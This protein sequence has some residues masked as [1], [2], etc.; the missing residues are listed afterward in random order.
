MGQHVSAKLLLIQ[1]FLLIRSQKYH[2]LIIE[3]LG[4]LSYKIS[5]KNTPNLRFQTNKVN[6]PLMLPCSRSK[7]SGCSIR[8]LN[9]CYFID[10]SMVITD[11]M[12]LRIV[13]C[14]SKK[15]GLSILILRITLLV[16]VNKTCSNISNRSH[17]RLFIFSVYEVLSN[18]QSMMSSKT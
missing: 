4:K 13:A 10:F 16:L 17:S 1:T 15:L 7:K 6:F 9:V 12:H 18:E 5:Q 3:C 2:F 8:A 14:N 11:K